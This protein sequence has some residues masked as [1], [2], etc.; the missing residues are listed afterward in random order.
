MSNNDKDQLPDL[1]ASL[2]SRGDG[3]R[4]PGPEYFAELAERSM[5]AGKQRAVRTSLWRW[6]AAVAAG[7][8]LVLGL[9]FAGGPATEEGS[10]LANEMTE[11]ELLLA[12]ISEEDIDAYISEQL[13]DFETELLESAPLNE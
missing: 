11:S 8:L 9:W 4:T 6:S 2:K 5:A 7:L 13:Y 1:L 10:L 3:Y 12:D